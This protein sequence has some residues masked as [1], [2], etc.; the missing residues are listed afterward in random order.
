MI[1]ETKRLAFTLIELL[2]V[3]GIIGM[4]TAII[5]PAVRSARESNRR[6]QC[7]A[8]L[9]QLASAMM[10]H[11]NS[12]NAFPPGCTIHERPWKTSLSWRVFLLPYLEE[13]KAFNTINPSAD[14]GGVSNQPAQT[15]IAL[16]V[17]PSDSR[18]LPS[19][20]I[21]LY[22]SNYF[23]V[24]GAGKR[25]YVRDMLND[26]SCG[27]IYTD[28]VLFPGSKTT[29][30]SITDGETNTFS[31]GERTYIFGDWVKGA[32]WTGSPDNKMCVTATKN[33]VHP[34]NADL[35]T[36]GYFAGDRSAPP[37]ASRMLLNDLI[38]GS[39]HPGGANFSFAGGRVE[40]VDDSIDFTV[41][42]DLS[43]RNGKE[44]SQWHP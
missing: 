9:K 28:G 8:N 30:Q 40:F 11:H 37:G 4:L 42:Q 20:G 41:Y 24:A 5:I 31:I 23:G 13:Q 3:I 18:D 10:Q 7:A 25:G 43:T 35:N 16:L 1:P 17:C 2:V 15:Q 22:P 36:H 44:L 19:S 33:V 34:L 32:Y 12:H 29:H 27:D 6:N 26:G 38:F 14:G 21:P 39:E